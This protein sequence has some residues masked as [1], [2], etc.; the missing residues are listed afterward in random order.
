MTEQEINNLIDSKIGKTKMSQLPEATQTS[1]LYSIGYT[2]NQSVK[3]KANLLQGDPLTVRKTYQ[4]EAEA[5]ADKN[6]IDTTTSLPLKVGQFVSIVADTTTAKNG[7][8]RISSIGVDGTM[9]LELQGKLGDLSEYAKKGGS[10]KTL[11]EID[12]VKANHGYESNPKTLKEI[13]DFASQLADGLPE[14]GKYNLWDGTYNPWIYNNSGVRSDN[15]IFASTKPIPTT[16]SEVFSVSGLESTGTRNLITYFDNFGTYLSS[17]SWAASESGTD[18]GKTFTTPENARSFV[19]NLKYS[20]GGAEN[21]APDNK[22]MINKGSYLGYY[23]PYKTYPNVIY[24]TEFKKKFEEDYFVST[25]NLFDT[26]AIVYTKAVNN[27]GAV[28]TNAGHAMSADIPLELSTQYTIDGLSLLGMVYGGISFWNGEEHLSALWPNNQP[29]SFTTP[30]SNFTHITINLRTL[31]STPENVDINNPI[32][33]VKGSV[34]EYSSYYKM[35]GYITEAEY[36][37]RFKNQLNATLA[38]S[39]GNFRISDFLILDRRSSESLMEVGNVTRVPSGAGLSYSLRGEASKD[40]VQNQLYAQFSPN[41]IGNKAIY[42]FLRASDKEGNMPSSARVESKQ[43]EVP[44]GTLDNGGVNEDT[45]KSNYTHPSLAYSATP[46][47]G[48]KYWKVNSA[49][50]SGQGGDL[51]GAKWEDTEVFVSNNGTDWL[52]VQSLYEEPKAYTTPTLRLP[53]H[54]L[55]DGTLKYA[56]LPCPKQGKVLEISGQG[57]Y[58]YDRTMKTVLT[59][60]WCHDPYILADNGYIYIYNVY[61]L[62][63]EEG[64]SGG[65]NQFLV[66][67]R[68]QNGI[69]W[70]IVRGNGTTLPLTDAS[71]ADLMFTK[72]ENNVPNYLYYRYNRPGNTPAILKWA[73]GEYYFFW[74]NNFSRRYNATSPWAIDFANEE[75][76]NIGDFAGNHPDIIKYQDKVYCYAWNSGFYESSDK[77][78]NFTKMSNI[79]FWKGGVATIEYKHGWCIGDNGNVIVIQT[80]RSFLQELLT[81]GV[82]DTISTTMFH[83]SLITKFT[84]FAQLL[85]FVNTGLNEGYI[86]VQITIDNEKSGT[87]RTLVNSYIAQKALPKGVNSPLVKTKL[88]D[89]INFQTGDVVTAWIALNSRNGGGIVFSTIYIE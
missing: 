19:V 83:S 86:D 10:T 21:I 54:N 11:K 72:D 60:P 71:K 32:Q 63:L 64:E 56:F 39:S 25:G 36:K 3:Y 67:I 65:Y 41:I 2:G 75:M 85:G 27:S 58:L 9:S 23:M 50:P 34:Q 43:F 1:G 78:L 35:K 69:D 68:T 79:P 82:D 87:S 62:T 30:A 13:D 33:L 4:T 44:S 5:L 61:H 15:A 73:T 88:F 45:P 76:V 49:Y 51:K 74:G 52:R 20:G 84:N 47:A 70:E 28:A 66:C 38:E 77:G 59:L 22:V 53:P 14:Y 46:I 57:K 16:G 42:G 80:Q 26:K 37:A 8:Y 7:I 12:D 55:T 6:P 40:I 18:L 24:N 48:Y 17:E 29:H 31:G 81:K 89:N